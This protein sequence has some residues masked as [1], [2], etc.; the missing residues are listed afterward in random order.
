VI[1]LDTNIVSESFRPRPNASVTAWLNAQP[2]SSFYL[3]TPVLAELRFGVERLAGGRRKRDLQMRIA[4][5]ETEFFAD[6]VLVFDLAAAAEFGRLTAQR[7]RAGRRM[8]PMD[9]CIAAIALVHRAEIATRD[10]NDFADIGLTVI[11][12]FE[13]SAVES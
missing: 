6:R 3:C 10:T 9:T 5:I 8:E 11:N 13:A 7:E 1:I 2:A 4:K 12:P